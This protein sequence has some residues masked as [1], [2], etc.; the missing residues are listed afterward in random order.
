[1]AAYK[2]RPPCQCKLR[3]AFSQSQFRLLALRDVGNVAENAVRLAGCLVVEGAPRSQHPSDLPV[4]ADDAELD[5]EGFAAPHRR[6]ACTFERRDVVGMDPFAEVRVAFHGA[7]LESEEGLELR[8]PRQLVS[9]QV[10]I[11]DPN[12]CPQLG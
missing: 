1:M 11:P 10:P 8:C 12:A 2:S 6:V 9:S 4:R 3:V 7:G 5:I